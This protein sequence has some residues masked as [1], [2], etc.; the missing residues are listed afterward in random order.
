MADRKGFR[1]HQGNVYWFFTI[2]RPIHETQVSRFDSEFDEKIDEIL[3]KPRT[4]Q[5]RLTKKWRQHLNSITHDGYGSFRLDFDSEMED[6]TDSEL[7]AFNEDLLEIVAYLPIVE[8]I[9]MW[10]NIEEDTEDCVESWGIEDAITTYI[11]SVLDSGYRLKQCDVED[12]FCY[13]RDNPELINLIAN[14]FLFRKLKGQDVVC[15]E[16]PQTKESLAAVFETA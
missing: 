12:I 1:F 3:L 6:Y 10:I 2:D 7:E 9:R 15:K 13:K 14:D 16:K 8:T 5:A 11:D 4:K